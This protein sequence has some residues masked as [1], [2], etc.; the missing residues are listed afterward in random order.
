LRRAKPFEL[1][2]KGPTR[3]A[4]FCSFPSWRSPSVAAASAA[5]GA[6]TGGG[7]VHLQGAGATFPNPLY[8]KWVSEYG[9]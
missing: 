8:Q 4:R 7:S 5:G 3:D 6:A 9:K 1:F 2:G